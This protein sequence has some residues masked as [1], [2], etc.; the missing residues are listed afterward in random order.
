MT[1]P[2]E[3]R[4]TVVAENRR[5]NRQMLVVVVVGV[6]LL[7]GIGAAGLISSM[8][9]NH[10]LIQNSQVNRHNG[11]QI[12]QAV[13]ILTDATGPEAQKRQAVALAAIIDDLR[14]STDCADI[15]ILDVIL[16]SLGI[17]PADHPEVAC[18]A[19]DGRMDAIRDG[20]DPF[21]TAASPPKGP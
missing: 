10:R 17:D 9:T 7:L 6:V 5:T 18:P 1:S 2:S 11:D 8:V 16:R 21:P 13:Q 12:K 4:E 19:V 15:Y 20:Q 14:K 3:A